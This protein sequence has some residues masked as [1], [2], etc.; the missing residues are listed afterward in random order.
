[1]PSAS[2]ACTTSSTVGSV[3]KPTDYVHALP[4]EDLFEHKR[5]WDC[6]C[7]PERDEI[8]PH[9][10]IHTYVLGDYLTKERLPN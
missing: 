10:L 1:M 6:W 7:K 2:A 4:S 5:D 8:T 3:P 9:I